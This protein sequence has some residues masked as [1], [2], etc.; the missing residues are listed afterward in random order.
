M[1]VD[2]LKG[3]DQGHQDVFV[4]KFSPSRDTGMVH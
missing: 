4:H 2:S 3:T 1:S